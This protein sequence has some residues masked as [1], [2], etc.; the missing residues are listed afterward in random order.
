MVDVI[1]LHEGHSMAAASILDDCRA[2]LRDFGK[3]TIGHSN[4]E[5]NIVAH[6]L[7][8]CGRANTP[9]LWEDAP[10]GTIAKICRRC[11]HYLRLIKL[12]MKA[13]P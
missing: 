1:H 11:K 9:S 13:F 12:G 3:I 4:R 6:E 5:L 10:M 7:A 2:L 8:E